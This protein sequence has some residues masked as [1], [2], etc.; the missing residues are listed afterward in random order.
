MVMGAGMAEQAIRG[1]AGDPWAAGFRAPA[2]SAGAWIV[3]G[4]RWMVSVGLWV[5]GAVV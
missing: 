1:G 4:G 3:N 2:A 5:V